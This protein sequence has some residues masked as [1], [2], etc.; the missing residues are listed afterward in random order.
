M[1]D[2]R[3]YIPYHICPVV[4]I[5]AYLWCPYQI[6]NLSSLKS[7]EIPFLKEPL[8]AMFEKSGFLQ[9]GFYDNYNRCKQAEHAHS[10]PLT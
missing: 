9:A 10:A 3:E 8:W 1:K 4:V 6:K 7:H 5:C 2:I